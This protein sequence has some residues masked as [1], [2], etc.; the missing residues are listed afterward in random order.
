[1]QLLQMATGHLLSTS[2]FLCTEVGTAKLPTRMCIG[3]SFSYWFPKH[4]KT[5][6]CSWEHSLAVPVAHP[7]QSALVFEAAKYVQFSMVLISYINW[8]ICKNW[9]NLRARSW[10]DTN[11]YS[12]LLEPHLYIHM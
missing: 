8:T 10:L 6:S 12:M 4:S 5:E 11:F 2:V 9:R 7:Q 3:I 1:M